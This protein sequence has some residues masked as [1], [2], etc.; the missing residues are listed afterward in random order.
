MPTRKKPRKRAPGAGRPAVLDEPVRFSLQLG[1]ADMV[2]LL[3]EALRRRVTVAELIRE[4]IAEWRV[5]RSSGVD[6][7]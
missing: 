2:A 7:R 5:G 3:A 6:A 4:A 1:R